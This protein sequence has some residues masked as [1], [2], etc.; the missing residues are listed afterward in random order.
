MNRLHDALIREH[1]RALALA[2][3]VE[4]RPLADEPDWPAW[5]DEIEALDEALV[6]SVAET[7][8]ELTLSRIEQLKEQS[9]ET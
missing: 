6:V 7:E 4:R 3:C 1:D 8:L 2:R 5:T 9:H